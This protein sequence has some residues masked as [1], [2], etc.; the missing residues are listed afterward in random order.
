VADAANQQTTTL[1]VKAAGA[2]TLKLWRV[3]PGIAFEKLVV[4]T[5]KLPES[6]LGPPETVRP[7]RVV[8]CPGPS[9]AQLLSKELDGAEDVRCVTLAGR[10]RPAVTATIASR[11]H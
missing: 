9:S 10:C 8:Q 5:R 3:D 2:H 7:C 11:H 6:Y 4:A 1:L